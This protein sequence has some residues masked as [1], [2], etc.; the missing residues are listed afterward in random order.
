MAHLILDRVLET[1]TTTGQGI[2]SLNGAVAGFRPFSLLGNGNTTDYLII[3]EDRNQWEIGI[4]TYGSS[5]NTLSRTTI[6][7]S[8]NSNL[9][10]DFQTG[11]KY[12]KITNAASKSI[13]T[14][15]FSSYAQPIDADLTAIAALSG[16][17]GLLKKTAANTWTL[18]T[19][20]YIT[21]ITSG[22]VT[23]A[24]GFTP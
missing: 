8:T 7:L 10:V 15:N 11:T 2:V 21:G 1:T 18:D 12:V 16:T 19:S 14:D 23:T 13:T 4:G 6:V 9:A 22:M 20:A 5:G 24:L 3:D 17:S